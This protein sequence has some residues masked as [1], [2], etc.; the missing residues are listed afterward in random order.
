[1]SPT[2]L[3]IGSTGDIAG[4]TTPFVA[5][6]L[7]IVNSTIV[8]SGA[9]DITLRSGEYVSGVAS[10]LITMT[11]PQVLA[12]VTPEPGTLPLLGVGLGALGLLIR[13]SRENAR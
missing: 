12:Q 5:G 1:M 4:N 3:T 7:T 11:V 2:E 6:T 9:G 8:N 10:G 13:R